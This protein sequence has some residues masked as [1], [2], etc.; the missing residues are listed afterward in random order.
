M[1]VRLMNRFDA[2]ISFYVFARLTS[3]FA[4]TQERQEW[5]GNRCRIRVLRSS[6]DGEFDYWVQYDGVVAEVLRDI[7]RAKSVPIS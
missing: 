5:S 4:G 6:I 3:A 2:P 1:K 7:D